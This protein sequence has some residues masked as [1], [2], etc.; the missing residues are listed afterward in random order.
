MVRVLLRKLFDWFSPERGDKI[1]AMVE[2]HLELTQRAVHE[3]YGMVDAAGKG[4]TP[5]VKVFFGNLIQMNEKADTLRHEM[6]DELTKSEMFPEERSDFLDLVRSV[7]WITDWSRTAGRILEII[8]FEKAPENIK[9]TVQNISKV[10]IE[11]VSVLASCIALLTKDSKETISLANRVE[12][13]EE[14]ADDLYSTAIKDFAVLEFKDFSLGALILLN[15]LFDAMETITDW[16]ENS[17]DAVR[18]MAVR[19]T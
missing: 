3:L 4:W 18:S 1:L 7:N 14:E 12:R 13:L 8:P 10:N 6:I 11:C 2:N 19:R 17:A 15:R 16:C 5:D 9:I